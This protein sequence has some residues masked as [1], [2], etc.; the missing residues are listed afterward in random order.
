MYPVPPAERFSSVCGKAVKKPVV[1]GFW[2]HCVALMAASLPLGLKG[3]FKAEREHSFHWRPSPLLK[4]SGIYDFC[5]STRICR[6]VSVHCHSKGA[7]GRPARSISMAVP[8]PEGSDHGSGCGYRFRRGLRNRSSSNQYS[9]DQNLPV[10]RLVST[11][12]G[13]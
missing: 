12:T 9:V 6:V 2:A 8:G 4:S 1:M 13:G 5:Q 10:S 3:G 7:G 11:E